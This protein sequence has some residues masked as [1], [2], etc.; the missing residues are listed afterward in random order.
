[1]I[2]AEINVLQ[3]DDSLV[4]ALSNVTLAAYLA[5]GSAYS[6]IPFKQS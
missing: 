3:Y 1:M 6:V 2:G 5:N 4:G